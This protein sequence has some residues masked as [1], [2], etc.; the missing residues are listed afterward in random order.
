M[1]NARQVVDGILGQHDYVSPTLDSGGGLDPYSVDAVVRVALYQEENREWGI[2]RPHWILP[3]TETVL[4]N[5]PC[6]LC[7]HELRACPVSQPLLGTVILLVGR[8]HP[9]EGCGYGSEMRNFI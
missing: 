7:G 2:N 3:S 4:L 1:P 5:T 6:T 8:N 9:F